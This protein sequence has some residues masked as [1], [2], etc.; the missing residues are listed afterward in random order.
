MGN[1]INLLNELTKEIITKIEI[2]LESK[3]V[4]WK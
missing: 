1:I 2:S 4:D 3:I